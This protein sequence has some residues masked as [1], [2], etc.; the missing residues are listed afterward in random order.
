[1]QRGHHHLGQRQVHR[2]AHRGGGADFPFLHRAEHGQVAVAV[3]EAGAGE[4]LPEGDAESEEVGP[5]VHRLASGLLGSH[6]RELA[7]E[8]ARGAG[9]VAGLG[10]AKVGQ[11]HRPLVGDEDVVWRDVAV[12]EAERLAV[13]GEP[14]RVGE[15]PGDLEADLRGE[16]GRERALEEPRPP[17]QLGQRLPPHVLHGEVVAVLVAVEVEDVDHVGVVQLRG[18]AGLGDEHL[19]EARVVGERRA[20]PLDDHLLLEALGPVGLRE[21]DL[22]HPALGELAPDH[23]PADGGTR[24]EGH[25]ETSRGAAEI[26]PARTAQSPR[27]G[28]PPMAGSPSTAR[29]LGRTPGGHASLPLPVRGSR[30]PVL[31]A[32]EHL[33]GGR[34]ELLLGVDAAGAPLRVRGRWTLEPGEDSHRAVVRERGE[35]LGRALAQVTADERPEDTGELPAQP[36]VPARRVQR[37]VERGAQMVELVEQGLDALLGPAVAEEQRAERHAVE[38]PPAVDPDHRLARP[39]SGRGSS[40]GRRPAA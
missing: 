20:N 34:V 24:S 36:G 15:P 30:R 37:A 22:R 29:P 2:P 5:G 4:Q 32:G 21:K 35:H 39:R 16:H 40:P 6:V 25:G 17:V 13:L 28:A 11:L 14:V 10:D 7:L 19:H 23:V 12:D 38:H 18:D 3:E 27:L 9:A 1:M 8:H 26:I 31:P 33:D